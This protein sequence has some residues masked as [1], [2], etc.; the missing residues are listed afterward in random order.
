MRKL[1]A[2]LLLLVTLPAFAHTGHAEQSVSFMNG[3]IHPLTGLD[4]MLA[5]FAVGLWSA[6]TTR[7]IWLAPVSFAATLLIGALLAQGGLALPAVEPIV[8]ASVLLLGLLVM[9]RSH[10]PEPATVALVAGFALFHGAAHGQEL[11]APIALAGMVLA[12]ALLHCMGI[13]VGLLLKLRSLWW[14]RIAGAGIA[15]AGAGLAVGLMS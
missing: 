7:R 3:F 13:A 10:F 5:M 2:P 12:T 15:L 6:T 4:H 11:S 1:I 9:T 8:A 14:Q